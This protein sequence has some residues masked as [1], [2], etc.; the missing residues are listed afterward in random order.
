MSHADFLVE[1]GT[2]ELP[3][4]ALLPMS[5]AFSDSIAYGLREAKL[6]FG[7]VRHYA[8]PRRLAVIVDQLQLQAE[9]QSAEVLGPPLAQAKDENGEWTAAANGFAKKQ[10]VSVDDLDIADTDKGQRLAYR[11]EAEGVRAADCLGDI[12]NAGVRALPIPKRMRWG[13]GLH[14]FVRPVHWVVAL[15]GEDVIDCEVLGHK[16]GRLSRGHRFHRNAS[17]G[18]PGND[19]STDAAMSGASIDGPHDDTSANAPSNDTSIDAAKI[20][21]TTD[22]PSDSASANTPINDTSTDAAQNLISIDKPQNYPK[23]LKEAFVVASFEERREQI[24][25]QVNALAESVGANAM[26]SSKPLDEGSTKKLFQADEN[27]E[28]SNELLDENAAQDSVNGRKNGANFNDD[29]LDEV[30]ALVEW[31]VALMGSFDKRF[32][33]VPAEALIASMKGHQKYF[34]LWGKVDD[35]DGSSGRNDG[36][37]TDGNNGKKGSTDKGDG[38]NADESNN[39]NGDGNGGVRGFY[40]LPRFITVSNLDSADPAQVVAGNERVIRPRLSDAEFFFNSDKQRSL[41]GRVDDLGGIV[42]QQKLGTLLDK[43]HRLVELCAK[44]ADATGADVKTVQRAARLSKAD[45]LTLMVGEFPSMQGIAGRY[46]LLA[47]GNTAKGEDANARGT[48]IAHALEQQYWPKFAGD[49]LPQNPVATCLALADRLDTIVGI[50]GIGQPPTGTKDP[51][52]LRRASLGVLRILNEGEIKLAP[53]GALRDTLRD[54]LEWTVEQYREQTVELQADTVE[55]VVTYMVERFPAQFED[56]PNG[57]KSFNAVKA[58]LDILEDTIRHGQAAAKQQMGDLEGTIRQ[59]QAAAEQ[60]MG[61]LKDTIR[62]FRNTA[63]RRSDALNI[64]RYLQAITEQQKEA[65]DINRYLQAISKQPVDVLDITRRTNAVLEFA[66]LPE[67]PALAAA[68]KRVANIL[69]KQAASV[70][71]AAVQLDL[72]KE[73]AEQI[74]ALLVKIHSGQQIAN[75]ELEKVNQA[76]W[77]MYKKMITPPIVFANLLDQGKYT[78]ALKSLASLKEPV[79][80]FFDDVMVMVDDEALRNNRLN[81]LREL[82]G[83]FLQVADISKLA[84]KE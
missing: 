76:A 83:L 63:E 67:A 40:L 5:R 34:P 31:P 37:G 32:L 51:F 66:K 71:A 54:I 57:T 52:A 46:Y 60:Q 24:R 9:S 27:K 75:S 7:E 72:L 10:G 21:V 28:N 45:L 43:T 1:I 22:K 48:E 56:K 18:A 78:E 62:Q 4:K 26:I 12:I 29:L 58:I 74:L 53:Q 20:S 49:R 23:L 55:Q 70:K 16:A 33:D 59:G 14:E 44:L 84:V 61:D 25:Q 2:E 38:K 42:F 79:D 13:S 6:D 82:R 69:E 15:L 80:K 65:L 3:P 47:E 19:T 17:T 77:S 81:L 41:E 35:K 8:T 50:F 64:N 39:E 30:T 73:P 11:S 68:N 36:K